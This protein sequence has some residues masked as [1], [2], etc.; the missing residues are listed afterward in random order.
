MYLLYDGRVINAYNIYN[1]PFLQQMKVIVINYVSSIL[2]IHNVTIAKILVSFN[3]T[4]IRN[5]ITFFLE[6]TTSVTKSTCNL[7]TLFYI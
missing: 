6:Y 1:K 2:L 3:D 7:D 5:D 4:F